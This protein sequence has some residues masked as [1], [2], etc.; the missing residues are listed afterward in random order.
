MLQDRLEMR[1]DL[2][3]YLDAE[4][5]EAC[6]WNVASGNTLREWCEK[7]GLPIA[8]V[9]RFIEEDASRKAAYEL[10]KSRCRTVMIQDLL[11]QLWQ[12]ARMDKADIFN[13]DG[14]M[15]PLA[16]LDK[17]LRSCI[18]GIEFDK[19]GGIKKIT[20]MR[21][22]AVVEQLSKNL[23]TATEYKFV[24]H[25]VGEG[26][27]KILDELAADKIRKGELPEMIEGEVVVDPE[28]EPE[29]DLEV[30]LEAPR[31]EDPP[32]ADEPPC[33]APGPI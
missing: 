4:A 14:T 23:G 29:P 20:F 31:E 3:E 8:G 6:C 33:A 10:A 28:P 22:T 2:S 19:E 11:I 26:F 32:D 16:E 5:F 13:D 30:E 25:D 1:A 15:K 18:E 24:Q 12:A 7:V 21:K 27:G 17:T 9:M